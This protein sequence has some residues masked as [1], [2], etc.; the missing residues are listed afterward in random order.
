MKVPATR[1]EARERGPRLFEQSF[2]VR[3]SYPVYFTRGALRQDCSIL[4][5]VLSS[6]PETADARVIAVVD[7][8][9]ARHHP[10][11]MRVLVEKAQLEA[12]WTLVDEPLLVPG[13]ED[14]KNDSQLIEGLYR[15]FEKLGLDRHA[16]VLCI[17]GGAVLDAVGFAAATTHRG[18]R[19]VRMPTTVLGQNDSGVGVKNGINRFGAK[20]FIGSFAPPWAVVNDYDFLSTLSDRDFRAGLAE[21]LKVAL[22]K[23]GS[24]FHWMQGSVEALGRREHA[25][26]ETAVE[27]TALLHLE[28]ISSGGDPFEAGSSRPLDFG[29]WAAHKLES[30]TKHQLRHGEAVAIGIALD[31]LYS[32]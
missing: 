22:I 12:G 25:V 24:F 13:G 10:S 2:S 18:L 29:H 11:L 20:N 17:G 30:L 28:H 8:G 16:Y 7:D 3:H 32:V 21:S 19:L 5:T 1:T 4:K 31:T 23:D 9:V 14:A 15:K 26:V 6:S 27:R